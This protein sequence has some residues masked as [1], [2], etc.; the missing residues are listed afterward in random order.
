VGDIK[1]VKIVI[2]VIVKEGDYLFAFND[3]EKQE[4]AAAV[5]DKLQDFKNEN[6]RNDWT[7][8]GTQFKKIK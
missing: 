6:Y 3:D 5:E 8:L 4:L 2:E 7:L 1:S